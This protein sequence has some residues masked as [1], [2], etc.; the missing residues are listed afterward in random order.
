MKVLITGAAGLLGSNIVRVLKEQSH[1]PV[2]LVRKTTDTRTLEG[3]HCEFREGSVENR[4]EVEKAVHGCDAIIHA[5]SIY[6]HPENDYREFER[7]NVMGTVNMIQAALK[8]GVKKFIYISTANTIAAGSK[9]RLG[10]ELNDFD[11]FHLES[12]YLNSKYV[13]E[14]YTLEQ[15]EKQ[16]L[17]AT[18]I[19]PTFMIGAY[20]SKPAS[21]RII[22][23]GMKNKVLLAPPGGKNFVHVMDVAKVT[24]QALTQSKKGGKYLVAGENYTYAEFFRLLAQRTGNKKAILVIPRF[25]FITAAYLAQLIMGKKTEFNLSNA[26]VLGR[27]NY[28]S[29]KKAYRA[30][31][32]HPT[33]IQ[34]ALEDALDWFSSDGRI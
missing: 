26:R 21:G 1:T 22:L 13:A 9:D 25:L 34:D 4:K 33:S 32:Y 3:L 30:F 10:T 28:Y 2:C 16:G 31:G 23:Y 12:N 5:A 24:V 20:D 17:D 27:D 14:Q 15:V 7:V 8:F 19:H 11:G 6:T 18:I 29:G